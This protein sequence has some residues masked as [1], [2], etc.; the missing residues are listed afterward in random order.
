M[1]QVRWQIILMNIFS[2]TRAQT[3]C[4][5]WET[6]VKPSIISLFNFWLFLSQDNR[7]SILLLPSRGA[8]FKL[9]CVE[10]HWRWIHQGRENKFL[11]GEKRDFHQ[12]QN[13]I[14]TFCK[15]VVGDVMCFQSFSAF[16]V[17]LRLNFW[18]IFYIRAA[19]LCLHFKHFFYLTSMASLE[20]AA[21]LT[22]I[23]LDCG[24]AHSGTEGT[25]KLCTGRPHF[26]TIN[27][28][29][30]LCKKLLLL[31]PPYQNSWISFKSWSSLSYCSW[32]L[33]T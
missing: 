31:L 15:D 17:C 19:L 16:L 14:L 3:A 33:L 6:P 21:C 29:N 1:W 28:L 26:M 22:S 5:I 25:C 12:S 7:P 32:F 30:T 13:N 11:D 8:I 10:L 4:W 2:R 9:F 27:L 24:S 18:V 20:S 23:F